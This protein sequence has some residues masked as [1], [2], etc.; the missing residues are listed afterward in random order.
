MSIKVLAVGPIS[1]P[2][3]GQSVAF[4]TYT[5][6]S[7][8]NIDIFNTSSRY[9][10]VFFKLFNRTIRIFLYLYLILK[11]KYDVLYIT[12]SRSNAGFIFDFLYIIIFKSMSNGKVV[13]HLHGAD[14]YNYRKN[15]KLTFLID[16]IYKKIDISIV[17]TEGMIEQYKNYPEMKI[18]VVRNFSNI[19]IDDNVFLEK[20][21]VLFSK[22]EINILY[23]SNVMYSKGIIHLLEAVTE[24]NE[25]NE[26]RDKFNISVAGDFVSDEYKK[27]HDIKNKFNEKI[28]N[29]KNI[30]Y[31]GVL[32]GSEKENILLNSD[33]F[34]LPTFYKTEAQP[35]SI[36]EAMSSGCL[37]VT[38]DHNYNLELVNNESAIII[39]KNNLKEEIK[40]SLKFI[41]D[42]N[43]NN[44]LQKKCLNSYEIAKNK[45][46]KNK[47][48]LSIDKIIE[49]S[50]WRKLH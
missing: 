14:F 41:I 24:L 38:T 10:Q 9:P 50:L 35:I 4:Q 46:S 15:S 7:Q 29:S 36:I 37:I 48:I 3:T 1:P 30:K 44:E 6:N 12:T 49:D 25:D 23:L 2:I 45:Y 31:L 26:Y 20:K 40:K 11:N 13:N 21:S 22:K 34:C 8:L 27:N 28:S 32:K 17:L 43:N 42:I 47:Y 39:A 16:Y 33:V 19:I 18:Y 5:E